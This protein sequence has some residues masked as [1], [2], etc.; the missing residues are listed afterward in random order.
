MKKPLLGEKRVILRLSDEEINQLC[1]NLH[2][3]GKPF[4]MT[5]LCSGSEISYITSMVLCNILK[6]GKPM[7]RMSVEID[8]RIGHRSVIYVNNLCSCGV[9]AMD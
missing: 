7:Q 1:K 6:V 3:F 8:Q 5:S 4:T 2:N 9:I